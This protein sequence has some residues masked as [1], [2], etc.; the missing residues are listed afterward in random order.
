MPPDGTLKLA[1]GVALDFEALGPS[2]DLTLTAA[3]F[4]DLY[5]NAIDS[6]TDEII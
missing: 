2:I 1:S 5:G 6:F 4:V 3:D